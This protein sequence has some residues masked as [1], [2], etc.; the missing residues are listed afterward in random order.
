MFI[1]TSPKLV[2]WLTFDVSLVLG[3]CQPALAQCKANMKC[4]LGTYIWK[5][6]Y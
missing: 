3:Q 2:T 4:L 1:S 6:D 5:Y